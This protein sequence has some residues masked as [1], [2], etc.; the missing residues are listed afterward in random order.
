MDCDEEEF[1]V[2][3]NGGSAEDIQFDELVGVVENFMVNFDP[4]SVFSSLPPFSSIPNEHEK[5]KIHRDVITRVESDLD[6]YVLE[7]CQAIESMEVAANLLSNRRD[8]IVDEVWDFVSEGCFDYLTFLIMWEKYERFGPEKEDG[9]VVN[10]NF[11][12]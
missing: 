9:N 10:G 12:F 8:E 2:C 6:A 1:V 3:G 7:N 5:Q 11:T 4:N